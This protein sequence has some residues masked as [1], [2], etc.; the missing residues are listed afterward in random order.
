MIFFEQCGQFLLVYLDQA[1]HH[2][3]TMKQFAADYKL[4]NE[5][6]YFSINNK[7][8]TDAGTQFTT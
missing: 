5:L 3:Y 4:V 8:K 6:G 2:G 7:V 1:F